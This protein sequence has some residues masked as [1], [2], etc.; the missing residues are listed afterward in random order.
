MPVL[1]LPSSFEK[2][3]V[4]LEIDM[5]LSLRMTMTFLVAPTQLL[6]ASKLVPFTIDASPTTAT[7]CSSVPLR[8]RAAAHPSATE[9]ATP[10]WPATAASHA[11][12]RGLGKPEIPPSVH[13]V[14]SAASRPVRIFQAYA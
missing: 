8:S 5:P 13:S 1:S 6:R 14:P 3:P 2:L 4:G 10:A 7:A 12:S 11:D 9:S